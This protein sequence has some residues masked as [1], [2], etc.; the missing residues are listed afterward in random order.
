MGMV[1]L[2]QAE[3][4][5]ILQQPLELGLL[6][7]LTRNVNKTRKAQHAL[8]VYGCR[9]CSQ[10][11]SVSA[12]LRTAPMPTSIP[13]SNGIVDG[14]QTAEADAATGTAFASMATSAAQQ[15]SQPKR[16]EKLRDFNA[17]RSHLK[18]SC[19]SVILTHLRILAHALLRQAWYRTTPGRRH[20]PRCAPID[21]SSLGNVVAVH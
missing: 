19:V 4:D 3:A 5:R 8:P 20:F 6:R 10:P 14:I 1:L 2:P 9:H 21:Q 15:D 11:A 17:L 12:L 18:S 13:E 7:E 16:K